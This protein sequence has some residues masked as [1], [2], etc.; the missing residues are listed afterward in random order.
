[1]VAVDGPVALIHRRRKRQHQRN[2]LALA[3][4]RPTVRN[5]DREFGVRY[6]RRERAWVGRPRRSHRR[7]SEQNCDESDHALCHSLVSFYRVQWDAETPTA[8]YRVRTNAAISLKSAARLCPLPAGQLR[9]V[10][11]S[12]WPDHAGWCYGP[13]PVIQ[14]FM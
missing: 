9:H 2:D 12:S 5:A 6:R 3:K 8:T 1:M 13:V 4:R 7:A 11:V 14:P 10:T